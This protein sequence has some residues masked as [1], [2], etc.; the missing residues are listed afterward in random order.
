MNCER[1][2]TK[3]FVFNFRLFPIQ[4]KA[5]DVLL[6]EI[7]ENNSVIVIG[8]TGS[9][10]TTQ[11]AQYLYEEF[12]GR[13]GAIA[14]T[15]PRRLAAKT[16]ASRVAEEMGCDIGELV[17][18]N[19]R[20]DNKTTDKT[21]IKFLTDGM[22]LRECMVD[23]D[24]SQ[25]SYILIDEAHER[26]IN[27]DILCALVRQIQLRRENL[28]VV[29]MSATLEADLF[30]SYFKAKVLYVQGRQYPVE[31]LYTNVAQRQWMDSL[32]ST[33]IQINLEEESR[34]G[35]ILA[36]L[37]GKE[38]I[39]DVARILEEKARLFPPQCAKLIVC[40][41]YAAQS[42]EQQESAFDPTPRGCRKV[43]LATNIA[44]TSITVPNI[45]FVIDSGLVKQKQ[46]A[47]REQIDQLTL[48][49]ETLKK[50]EEIN[51]S[52]LV[53]NGIAGA[54][55]SASTPKSSKRSG[56]GGHVDMLALVSVSKAQAWQRAGRAGRTQAGKTYRLYTENYFLH[57]MPESQ[58]AEIRRVDLTNLILQ[59]MTIGVE[60]VL[61]F[62]WLEAPD[63]THLRQALTTLVLHNAINNEKK[64][65]PLGRK[66]SAFP[67]EPRFSKS[68]IFSQKYECTHAVL[69]IVAM[70]N[71][72]NIFFA[73]SSSSDG[74]LGTSDAVSGSQ[75]RF[76]T[77]SVY[78]DNGGISM[79]ARSAMDA[80]RQTFASAMGDHIF[81][82][83]VFNAWALESAAGRKKWCQT[84]YVNWR[85][86]QQAADIRTQL[87]GYWRDAK[88]KL[89][90]AENYAANEMAQLQA[91]SAKILAKQKS[92]GS[93]VQASTGP[94]EWQDLCDRIAKSFI[95][96]FFEQIAIKRPN[97][98]Y[99]TLKESEP[100]H[101][102]PASVMFNAKP[103]CVL[104]NELVYTKNFYVRDVL[105]IQR[106]WLDECV[107]NFSA[108]LHKLGADSSK[109]SASST[110]VADSS[111]FSASS[112]TTV[113]S[114]APSSSTPI[115]K[116]TPSKTHASPHKSHFSPHKTPQKSH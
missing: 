21:K 31:V 19:V 42:S 96:G 34:R 26:S 4:Y 105:A 1:A 61:E 81:L 47:T 91:S 8:E 69:T 6:K 104:F 76:S 25:Y 17:G 55:S 40:P 88:M 63:K 71:T 59:L 16:T 62:P 37:T 30:A 82:L 2:L 3:F 45:K 102:H 109:L 53:S 93:K 65:T 108:N 39:E 90:E 7:K 98:T 100:V 43:V 56:A 107:P 46:R 89:P 14:V 84:H 60:D 116:S 112:T 87:E 5:R 97:G 20:F 74:P 41:L 18:Y 77:R 11:L 36:F 29:V 86:M 57:S 92:D 49:I 114:S 38:E 68:L 23:R 51:N 44:E 70:L 12:G 66:M 79:H 75:S 94:T 80:A 52:K 101:I 13:G 33:V 103:E 50:K 58:V 35:D 113:A 67:I 54:S 95:M 72:E 9:G 22:L 73:P 111:K 10:K 78:D 24:L 115:S 15:Q 48:P 32:V 64:I 110:T 27:T 28:K 85:S 106:I 99:E 83:N